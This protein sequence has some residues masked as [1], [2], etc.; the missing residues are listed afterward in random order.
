MVSLF[1]P[2]KLSASSGKE[3]I[4]APFSPAPS[5]F[6]IADENETFFNVHK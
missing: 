4:S 1:F 5:A 6:K 2:M 3:A